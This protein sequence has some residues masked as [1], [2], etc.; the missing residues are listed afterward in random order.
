M[1]LEAAHD[2]LVVGPDF[3]KSREYLRRFFAK[4]T[5][6][7]YDTVDMQEDES[8][9]A[10]GTDFWVRVDEGIARNRQGIEGL[11]GELKQLGFH[12]L[13]DILH[14][15]QGFQSKIFH[16]AAHLLDGFIGIDT[17]FYSFAHDS[18]W[19]TEKQRDEI[20]GSPQ[21]YWLVRVKGIVTVKSAAKP[22]LLRS[23][24]K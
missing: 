20:K 21:D 24:E 5:L 1:R 10:S 18:H 16:T 14:I 11:I 19:L 3:E 9:S 8:M 2:L 15:K 4:T 7:R 22:S 13:E 17:S 12:S 23:Y 6:L